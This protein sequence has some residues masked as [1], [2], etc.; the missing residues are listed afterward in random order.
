MEHVAY[1]EWVNYSLSFL[2]LFNIKKQNFLDLACG[3]CTPTIY[4][5]KFAE[6]IIG[7]DRSIEMLKVAREKIKQLQINNIKIVSGDLRI[8]YF[9]KKFD[10]IFCF[11]D[12]INY[13]INNDDLL[14]VFKCAY[15]NLQPKGAFIFDMNTIFALRDIWNTRT[16]VK[17]HK[18][19]KSI[20]KNRWNEKEKISELEI[21]IEWEEKGTKKEITEFHKEKGYE[22][23]E[24]VYLLKKSGFRNV[25][26]YEHLKFTPPTACTSRVQ[27]VCIK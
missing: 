4:L 27:F 11:F 20:W 23:E 17:V 21:T 10:S 5:S 24:V 6:E 26:V 13:I 9:K 8:F 16:E 18:N 2:S 7:L 14:K 22:I 15:E 25:H 19:F 12:S 3:T 1:Q